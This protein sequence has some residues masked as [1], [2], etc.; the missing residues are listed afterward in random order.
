MKEQNQDER[1]EI[2]I[3]EPEAN[4]IEWI[5]KIKKKNSKRKLILKQFCKWT[6]NFEFAMQYRKHSKKSA[7]I[8]IFIF[9]KAAGNDMTK[10]WIMNIWTSNN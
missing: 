3:S 7:E 2:E 9:M 10:L 5:Q 8:D 1:E 4:E 6:R